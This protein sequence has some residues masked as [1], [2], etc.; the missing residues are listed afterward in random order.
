M[1]FSRLF[2]SVYLICV[3]LSLAVASEV[4][5]VEAVGV[6]T[7]RVVQKPEADV[8][9]ILQTD[10]TTASPLPND[11]EPVRDAEEIT[12]TT[13]MDALLLPPNVKRVEDFGEENR[14]AQVQ[15]GTALTSSIRQEEDSR[16]CYAETLQDGTNLFAEIAQS[17][18]LHRARVM[19]VGENLS[20][21]VVQENLSNE[22]AL[23][24]RGV[25]LSA[26]IHQTAAWAKVFVSQ[27]GVGHHLVLT[28]R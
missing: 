3:S 8:E 16:R 23:L 4:S 10:D 1:R 14:S 26:T 20:A 6:E 28:Q 27:V 5:F 13:E 15:I 25:S 24:Q 22:A 19:Q 18:E 11:S 7:D 21:T 12:L 2:L 9:R 17:G